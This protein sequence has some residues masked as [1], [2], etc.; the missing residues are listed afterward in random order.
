MN[1]TFSHENDDKGKIPWKNWPKFKKRGKWEKF[2][3]MTS[4]N[5]FN[6]QKNPQLSEEKKEESINQ[7]GEKDMKNFQLFFRWKM[8]INQ[9]FW[10]REYEQCD[11]AKRL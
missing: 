6:M 7:I 2:F 3:R 4:T 11:V 1:G 5:C 9:T 10:K 8:K